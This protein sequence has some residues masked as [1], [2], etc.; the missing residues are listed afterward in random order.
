MKFTPTPH[1][2]EAIQRILNE[3]TRAAL[4]GSELGTGKTLQAVE[5]IRRIGNEVNLVTAPLHT[6][7]GWES[8]FE[9][10]TGER[11]RFANTKTKPGREAMA[12]L[13][14]GVPGTYFMGRELARLQ[15]WSAVDVGTYVS[16]ECHSWSSNSSRGF[17]A[18]M[19]M[20]P[21]F[22][23]A[24]SATWFGSSFENAWA[25]PRVLWP[26]HTPGSYWLWRGEWCKLEYDPYARD[27]KKVT[28]EKNPGKWVNSLPCYIKLLSD[29]PELEP[30][31]IRYTLNNTQRRMYRE[32]EEQSLTWLKENPLAADLPIVQRIRLREIALATPELDADG[33]LHFPADA[34]SSLFEVMSDLE[35]D[36]IGEQVLMGTHSAKFARYVA[37]RMRST[38]AWT[39]VVSG[40]A[41]AEAKADFVAG[42]V[43]NIVATQKAIGEG[44]DS[45]Q[46]ASRVI[47]EL[48]L[49]DS[50]IMNQQFRGR[51]NRRG[52]L[53]RVLDYRFVASDTIDDPQH[54]SLLKKELQMRQS[55][56]KL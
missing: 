28:G 32:M 34:K 56:A 41:K 13:E 43:K 4:V 46:H 37:G 1:Q 33:V 40:E 51:L 25:V 5:A 20:K 31:I 22:A 3:P 16:D 21:D 19:R 36:L 52:Q 35:S 53:R 29:L 49:D 8:T 26:E 30:T 12:D 27:K 10:Q 18:N 48:S 39:G 47:F 17:K 38:F 7:D 14:W 45:L 50:P 24:Q 23:I 6:R 42:R 15:D 55:S 44:V 9:R 2:E 11:M 54:E